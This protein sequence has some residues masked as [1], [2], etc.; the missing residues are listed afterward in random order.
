MKLFRL[1]CSLLA[2]IAIGQAKAGRA[3]SVV[4]HEYQTRDGQT[5]ATLSYQA[6]I[7][8]GSVPFSQ[9]FALPKF[10]PSLGTLTGIQM[11]LVAHG[12]VHLDVYNLTD[13][14]QTFAG[15]TAT[16]P[17]VITGPSGLTTTATFSSCVAAGTALAGRGALTSFAGA[18]KTTSAKVQVDSADFAPYV[19]LGDFL[20]TFTVDVTGGTFSGTSTKLGALAFSGSEDVDGAVTITYTFTPF[21]VPEPASLSLAAAP[22]A[23]ALAALWH[24]RRRARS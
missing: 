5:E 6:T 13:S 2:A 21:A 1:G 12:T 20:S 11:T 3:E 15:A 24:R 18:T 8:T 4:H 23:V 16:I 17:T 7:A 22:A 9:E 14:A 10:D 19:G